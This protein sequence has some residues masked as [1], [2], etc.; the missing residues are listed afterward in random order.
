MD[1]QPNTVKQLYRVLYYMGASCPLAKGVLITC[2]GD[3]EPGNQPMS[4]RTCLE[5]VAVEEDVA[6]RETTKA[7]GDKEKL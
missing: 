5:A 7:R 1:V 6:G 2:M 4:G 3:E